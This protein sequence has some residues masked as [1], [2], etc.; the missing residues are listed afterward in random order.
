MQDI[1]IAVW[2]ILGLTIPLLLVACGGGTSGAENSDNQ[3][4]SFSGTTCGIA[5]FQ[6]DL[7]QSVNALRSSGAV[8]G[9]VVYPAVGALDWDGQLQNAATVHATDMA[10]HNFFAH[11]S[12]TTGKTFRERLRDAGY[13][14]TAGGENIAAGQTTVQQVMAQWIA[15]SS[16]CAAMLQATY[17]DMGVSCKNNPSSTYGNY[18]TMEMAVR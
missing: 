5:G 15:S 14:W 1:K 9:G 8:C 10:E 4:T 3:P 6:R 12:P 13:N 18:W 7:V 11:L 2:R 17:Q 16:H